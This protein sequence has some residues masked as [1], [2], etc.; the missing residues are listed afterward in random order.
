MACHALVFTFAAVV[1]AGCSDAPAPSSGAAPKAQP[2]T[3]T[4]RIALVMKSLANEF[5]STM[6]QGA[7]DHQAANAE[8]YELIVNGI[9]DETDLSG[10]VSLVEQMIAL[11]VDAIVIAPADSKALVPVLQRAGDAG[12]VVINID[13]KLDAEVLS[14][15]GITIPFVG[16]DNRAGAGKVGDYLASTLQAGDKV[17]VLEG[18]PTSF[19]GQQRKLGFEEAMK[20]AS[21][22]I[23]DSQSAKWEMS[24]GN[25]T[26]SGM[27]TAQPELKAIL[28]CNDSMAL[29]ALAAVKA[30]GRLETI[31][32]VGVDNIS[33][34]QQGIR[35]GEILATADQHGD[36]L[37]V[38]GIEYALEAIASGNTPGERETP[39]DLVT[40][41]TLAK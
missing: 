6:A 29:G 26:A 20:S 7:T 1:I 5:F 2:S 28:A 17:A 3:S 10:Q 25:Q 41:D 11:Q 35:D 40:V 31:K 32:I 19:N 22:N 36:Q 34:V 39:V 27:L 37:A 4:P 21:I 14:S 30:A 38:F 8:Q 16:P 33:A 24:L 13:N 12:I 18:L 23:V 9:K 15:S